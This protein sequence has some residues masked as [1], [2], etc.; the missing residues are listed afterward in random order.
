MSS[1]RKGAELS[2]SHTT[3]GGGPTATGD[4][5]WHA[6][7]IDCG[8]HRRHSSDN[9]RYLCTRVAR[10]IFSRHYLVSF[11]V[12]SGLMLLDVA[13]VIMDMVVGLRVSTPVL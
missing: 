6:A 10:D 4:L 2:R 12:R 9:S 1:A 5:N 8:R 11:G 3:F 7:D 13:G